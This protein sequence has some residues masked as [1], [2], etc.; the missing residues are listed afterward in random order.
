MTLSPILVGTYVARVHLPRLDSLGIPPLEREVSARFGTRVDSLTVLLA[1]EV[2][3]KTCPP[4]STRHGEGMLGRTVRDEHGNPLSNA[5][6]TAMWQSRF[7]F[8]DGQKVDNLNYHEE[9]I[10][11]MTGADGPFRLCGVP[12]GL[13]MVVRVAANSGT[14]M[15]RVGL[16]ETNAFTTVD[17]VVHSEARS[18]LPKEWRTGALVERVVTSA[19]GA[20]LSDVTL[21]VS[22]PCGLTRR[23]RTGASGRALVPEMRPGVLVVQ[24]RRVGCAPGTLALTVQPGRNTAPIIFSENAAPQLDTVRVLGGK[25]VTGRLDDFETR[26]VNRAATACIT[27]HDIERRHPEDARQLLSDVPLVRVRPFAQGVYV[28]SGRGKAPS[29][30]DPSKPRPMNVMHVD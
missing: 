5:V 11:A 22:A 6:V 15:R 20:P 9:T 1:E 27:R 16:P 4:D 7:A 12:R 10:G 24:A 14:D 29:L 17:L 21:D 23:L 25:K 26:R 28:T 18:A 30:S 19:G 13:N 2:L 3:R 8:G